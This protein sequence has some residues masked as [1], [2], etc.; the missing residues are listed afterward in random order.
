MTPPPGLAF[1][2]R[3]RPLFDRLGIADAWAITRGDPGVVVGVID[4]GFDFYHPDLRGQLRPGY[5]HPGGYH[6]ELFD[7]V[8]HG[9]SIA[10]LI[11][12]RGPGE[13]PV[14][15]LAPGC[16]AVAAC[17]GTLEHKLLR[18]QAEFTRTHPNPA[19]GEFQALMRE[20]AGELS[21]AAREWAVYQTEAT[22]AAVRDLVGRGVRVI[23]LS[24]LLLRGLCPSAEA[25]G[26][27]EVAFADAAGRGVLTVI[28]AGNDNREHADYPG[29][30]GTVLVAGACQL[31]GTRWE[32][33][34]DMV[35]MTVR[36]GSCYGPRLTCVAPVEDL[37]VL[38]PHDPRMYTA[39][40]GPTGPT[41]VPFQG[42]HT[43]TPTGATS[44]ATAIVSALAALVISARPDLGARAVGE[45]IRRGC[46][47]LAD[48]R[49]GAGCVHFGATLRLARD[50]DARA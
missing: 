23:N 20:H 14:L 17:L 12:G 11:V 16:I 9:T 43:V 38:A 46:T 7:V 15:G 28:G 40:D 36:Q 26:K 1:D 47:P 35:G 6:P 32:Q 4:S 19:P 42:P 48:R 21:R 24:G 37:L 50:A 33:D 8:V 41:D 34:R 22:T 13:Q 31:D 49:T 30:A 25:W 44:C 5:Y 3:Q 2:P 39:A 45:L 29:E 18:L 10:G 27:L